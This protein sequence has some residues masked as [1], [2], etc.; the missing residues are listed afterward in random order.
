MRVVRISLCILLFSGLVLSCSTP[1]TPAAGGDS[2]IVGNW[3][4]ILTPEK[5]FEEYGSYTDMDDDS[6]PDTEVSRLVLGSDAAFE[7]Y[8]A[9][10]DD[11]GDIYPL[12][13]M[14]KGMYSAE[15]GV[16]D[17]VVT[18]VFEEGTWSTISP[19]TLSLP[20]RIVAT[21]LAITQDSFELVYIKE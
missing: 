9:A 13:P 15:A 4:G 2:R 19:E 20:Y 5:C 6:L 12:T 17:L 11:D 10:Y 18:D 7:L 14:Y 21:A 16:L 8:H 1:T 3:V